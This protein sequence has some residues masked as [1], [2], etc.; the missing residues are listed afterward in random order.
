MLAAVCAVTI[1]SALFYFVLKGRQQLAHAFPQPAEQSIIG[2]GSSVIAYHPEAREI[3]E[4]ILRAG[5][6]AFDA[7][8]ATVAAENVLAEGASSL[9]GPLGVL[10]YRA[11]DNQVTYLDADFNDPLDPAALWKIN[12]RKLGKSALV[13]GAPAGLEAVAKKY[14]RFAFSELLQ[15][16]IALAENGFAVNRL[17]AGFI[18]HHSKVLKTTK[19][20]RRTFFPKG[21]PLAAGEILRQPELANFLRRLA[22]EG[23]AY[24]YRGDWGERFLSIVEEKGGRLTDKDLAQYEVN[25]CVPWT[26]TYRGYTIHSSSGHSYGGLWVL[27]ALKTL[28][29][30]T[31]STPPSATHYWQDADTLE[32]MIR[33]ARQVWS[34]S[35][36]LDHRVLDNPEIV[37]S[38]LTAEYASSIWEK[39]RNRVPP[40][41]M[42][43]KGSHSY[44]IIVTDSEGNIASG[45]TTI[46]SE[47]WAEGMFVEGVA[48]PSSGKIP[49]NTEPGR[50]R[51]SPFS[52]HL[53]LQ[54]GQ[55]RFAVG[56]ISNSVVETS[57]QFLVNLIDYQMSVRDSVSTPRFGTFPSQLRRITKKLKLQLDT[58]WLDPRV[59][60]S[61]VKILKARGIKVTQKGLID[62]GLGT[63]LRI[64]PE[65]ESEGITAP[66]PYVTNPFGHSPK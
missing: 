12:D 20:G 18:A 29:H 48:L 22:E 34:E 62:T 60:S 19:Y 53:A 4:A 61:V 35:D 39:V 13:P 16:A 15:P 43:S 55:S 49:W 23:S 46:E 52:I 36:L 27:L 57:F 26:T 6:N 38:R 33:I 7:F 59:D 25:W 40:N 9:A 31:L 10:I 5:G 45:T 28:E 21:K 41:V 3:G 2:Q 54:E 37:Q 66:V 50:R 8:V 58:N 17:M 44:H 1:I 24:V 47:P 56:A 51:L 11:E 32:R 30:T 42:G 14:G 63:V 65:G 64:N